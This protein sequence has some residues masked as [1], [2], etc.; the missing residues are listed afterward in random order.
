MILHDST[1]KT[2][3]MQGLFC[4]CLAV[5]FAQ[6]NRQHQV[7][8]Q[9]ATGDFLTLTSHGLLMLVPISSQ[10]YSIFLCVRTESTIIK[11]N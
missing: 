10:R 8:Q 5:S 11:T 4:A 9:R 6:V 3:D 2:V 7:I 1:G